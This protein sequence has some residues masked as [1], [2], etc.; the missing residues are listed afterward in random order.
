MLALLHTSQVH[1]P[2]FDRLRNEEAPTVTLY[3]IVAGHLLDEARRHG[4]PSVADQVAREVERA[5]EAGARA[6]LCTCSTIGEVAEAAAAQAGIPVLR[7]DRPMAA[8]AVA[9]GTRITVL[10][11]L[12]ATLAPTTELI[13]QEAARAGRTVSVSTRIAVGAWELFE[14]DDFDGYL[15]LVA[16]ALAEITDAD[17]IVLA[18]ASMAPLA[19]RGATAIPVLA[20]PRLGLRAAIAL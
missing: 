12:A 8:A 3:H 19:K 7:V 14:A 1:V 4:A 6:V 9:A 18:Q 17:V 2:T 11:A 15:D 20:S 16:E 5:A 13:E 10:A